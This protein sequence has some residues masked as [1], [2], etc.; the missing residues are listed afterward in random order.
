MSTGPVTATQ[1][2]TSTSSTANSGF[3]ALQPSDFMQMLITELQNQ[4]PTNPMDTSEMLDQITQISNI[5]SNN[6]LTTTLQG[7]L[8]GQNLSAAAGLMYQTVQG[9]DASG[10][11]VSGQVQSVSIANG[12]ATL[13]IGN[14][15]I[16]LANVS[17]ILP[18]T[19]GS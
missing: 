16:P 9:L 10:N 15:S 19:S 4:D 3:N 5:E 14:D 11:S 17:E 12:A 2:T 13:N 18:A 8:L 7:V 6:Q 1:S